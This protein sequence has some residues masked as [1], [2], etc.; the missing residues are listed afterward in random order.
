MLSETSM[1]RLLASIRPAVLTFALTAGVAVAQPFPARPITVIVPFPPGGSSDTIMRVVSKGAQ[2]R[3]GQPIVIENR[4]GAGGVVGAVSVKGAA[5]DGYMLYMG[6]TGT[7]V[8]NVS[9]FPKLEYDPQKDFKPITTLFSFPSLLVVPTGSPARTVQELV[10]LGRTKTGGLSYSSQG[11]GTTG[12]LIG[13]M[14][15]KET[16]MNLVHVPMKGA[17]AAVAEVASGRVDLLFSSYITAGPF[18]KDGKIRILGIAATERSKALPDVRTLAELGV[19]NVGL[20]QWFGLFAPAG[21]P[22]A[23]IRRL[24]EAFVA[25]VRTAEVGKLLADQAAEAL[26]SSPEAFTKQMA[27]EI[28]RIARV[29]RESGAKPE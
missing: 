7:H 22:D 19:P 13:D 9:L 11:I 24:N 29:V 14:M 2:E 25:S 26:G 21:T 10:Q 5:P 4:A 18:I 12:H 1:H 15:R 16:G 17:A 23:V 28:P 20:D 6:H 3:L 27:E 8:V